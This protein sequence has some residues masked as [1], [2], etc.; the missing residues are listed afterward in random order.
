MAA[1]TILRKCAFPL[2]AAIAFLIGTLPAEAQFADPAT[3]APHLNRPTFSASN[4]NV[5]EAPS[6]PYQLLPLAPCRVIDTRNANGPLGGPPIQGGTFR[7]FPLL[8]S[9]CG[10]PASTGAY[11][12]NVTVVPNGQLNSLVVYPTGQNPG[13]TTTMVSRDGRV[14]SDAVIVPAGSSGE[15]NIYASNTT[16]VVVDIYGSFAPPSDSSL[17]FYPLAACR[18]IDT[19]GP[20]GP[21]GGPFLEAGIERD[22]PLFESACVPQGA[23]VAAYSLNVAVLPRNGGPLNFLTVWPQ[24]E[25]Q[26]PLATLTDPT[27]TVVSNTDV[28][29]AGTGGGIAVYASNN[30]DLVVDINGV[31]ASPG[32]GGLSLYAVAPCHAVDTRKSAFGFTGMV[33]EPVGSGGSSCGLPLTAQAYVFNATAYPQG[34]LNYLTLWPDGEPMPGTWT[35][36]AVDG[37][38]TSNMAIVP[39]TNGFLDAYADGRTQLVLDISSYFAP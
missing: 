16:N 35:L 30:T 12:L 17:E 1:F 24:G 9:S 25:S 19:R 23:N 37:A 3:A 20:N 29:P 36:N 8:Q 38:A 13:L 39:R 2:W 28:V 22:F 6:A 32:L 10:I 27:G 21:L 26:P 7:S 11:L 14:K 15:I 5:A 34:A 4:G 33:R 18:V 31:F